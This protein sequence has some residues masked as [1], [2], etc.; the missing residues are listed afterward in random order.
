M[1]DLLAAQKPGCIGPMSDYA[2]SFFGNISTA[3]F[4]IVGT[5]DSGTLYLPSGFDH[6]LTLFYD[7]N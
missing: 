4:G 7:S 6:V 5:F 3:P 2:F 1:S